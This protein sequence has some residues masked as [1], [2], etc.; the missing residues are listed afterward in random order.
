MVPYALDNPYNSIILGTAFDY[1]ARL[2]I[3]RVAT[4][5]REDFFTELAAEKGLDEIK[6]LR[7]EEDN[8]SVRLENFYNKAV[9]L[10][11]D[12]VEGGRWK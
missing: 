1:I 7:G 10:M 8:I 2:M 3:A 11:R 6:R 4:N 9:N 12:F 5:N